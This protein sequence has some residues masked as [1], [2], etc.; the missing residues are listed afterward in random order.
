MKPAGPDQEP[1]YQ[2]VKSEIEKDISQHDVFLYMKGIP[3]AP[4]CGF[5]NLAVRVLDAYGGYALIGKVD[6]CWSTLQY[7][8]TYCN[9]VQAYNLEPGMFLQ[10]LLSVR[11]SRSI[12]SGRPSLRQAL[13]AARR[14]KVCLCLCASK[15][16]PANWVLLGLQVFINGQ[17]VGGSDILMSM[18]ESGELEKVLDPIIKKQQQQKPGQAAK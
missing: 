1:N 4:Q 14:A 13:I 7:A 6:A 5:S 8:A 18:H 9:H 16:V 12:L 3:R 11:A 17:F 2:Q 15:I 10:T